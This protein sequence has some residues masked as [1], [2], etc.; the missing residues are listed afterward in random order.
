MPDRSKA[1][2]AALRSAIA[3]SSLVASLAVAGCS[4]T[5]GFDDPFADY[6]QRTPL[7]ATTGG[8]AQAAN[9]VMQTATPWP[10]NAN[11]T[12]I[13]ANGARLVKVINRYESG[14]SGAGA[15]E[16]G[17]QTSTSP[18]ANPGGAANG[19]GGAGMTASPSPQPSGY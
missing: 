1:E 14:S 12:N 6:L 4:S 7:V 9:T 8:D 5:I 2:P 19:G 15:S 18:G 3:I 13:P 10:R 16:G 17:A 11:D